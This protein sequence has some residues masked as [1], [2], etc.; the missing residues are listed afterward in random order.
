MGSARTVTGVGPRNVFMFTGTA[1]GGETDMTVD[2]LLGGVTA[3]YEGHGVYGIQHNIGNTAYCGQFI[4]E[5]DSGDDYFCFII[6]RD[7][8]GITMQT[9]LHDGTPGKPNFIH[10]TIHDGGG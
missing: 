6:N 3:T 2:N 7:I 9:V 5:A 4:A 10:G 8:N 1:A